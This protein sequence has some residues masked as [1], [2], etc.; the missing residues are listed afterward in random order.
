VQETTEDVPAGFLMMMP[1]YENGAPAG[2]VERRENVRGFV[3]APF[4][5]N[6][7][8]QGIMGTT[9]G[10]VTFAIYDGEPSA[11]MLMFLT[12]QG[13]AAFPKAK[14]TGRLPRPCSWTSAAG[15]GR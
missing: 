10:D 11:D 2:T 12:T 15:R 13:S 4:R 3:Y 5:M 7:L 8:M 1:M 14:S 6:D 9:F